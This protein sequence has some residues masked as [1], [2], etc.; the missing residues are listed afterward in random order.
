LRDRWLQD[1]IN[2]KIPAAKAIEQGR[3]LGIDLLGR[4]YVAL[5]AECVPAEKEGQV[6]R[7]PASGSD[8]LLPVKIIF[9]S[10]MEKNPNSIWLQENEKC[11]AILVKDITG[12]EPVIEE[13]VYT[14]AQALKHEVERNTEFKMMIGIGP[15]A[16]RIGEVAKSWSIARKIINN[17]IARGLALIAD[18]SLLP[19]DGAGFDPSPLLS[20]KGDMFLTRLKYAAKK[21]IDDLVQE[22]TKVLGNEFNENQMLVFFVFGEIIV[23]ASKIVEAL[24]GDIREIS[25]S[26]LNQEDIRQ[27]ASSREV[28]SEK[29]KNLLSAVIEFRDANSSGRYQSVIIKAQE[30]I[31]RNFSS[32][33][34]SLYSTAS[35]VGI[36]P[37]HLSTV[38]AQETGEKFIDYLTRIRIEK[39][40]QLLR[41]TSMKGADIAY[42]A[43]F[44]DPHYFSSIFKKHT[45]LSPREFRNKE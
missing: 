11:Y 3:E 14:I 9:Q 17:G 25:P 28:F 24:G 38:F 31:D 29:V 30:Y 15:P 34:I 5:A 10:I 43:G 2:G 37:N 20:I 1:F 16:A 44:N 35:H 8:R 33:D 13:T 40:K 36:S 18:S 26:S 12:E 21:D 27:I 39:A 7:F 41:Y 19:G 45:G 32:A 22:Y 23:A 4:S 6:D 42:E